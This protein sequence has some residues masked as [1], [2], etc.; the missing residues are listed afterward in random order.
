MSIPEWIGKG[1]E[2]YAKIP[3]EALFGAV[4]VLSSILCFS[5][6]VLAGKDIAATPERAGF[7]VVDASVPQQGFR[8]GSS[9]GKAVEEPLP[10]I[11]EGGQYVAS[12]NGEAYYLPWCSGANRI[13]EENKIWFA[14]KEEAE[15]RGYRPAKTCK[16]M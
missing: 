1:K 14:S 7:A 3:T 16:G 15:G 9:Y 8:V 4:L 13:K 5:L 10:G 12:K 11:P 6:G 2:F